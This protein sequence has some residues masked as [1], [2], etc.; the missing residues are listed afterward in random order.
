MIEPVLQM[1]HRLE[2][3]LAASIIATEATGFKPEDLVAYAVAQSNLRGQLGVTQQIV[4]QIKTMFYGE[5]AEQDHN[6]EEE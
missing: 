2:Q 3:D 4:A 1:L 6:D 5:E